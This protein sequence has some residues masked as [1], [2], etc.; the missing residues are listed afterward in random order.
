MKTDAAETIA[1]QA[2]SWLVGNDGLRD[3]FLGSTG[4][5]ASDLKTQ[6]AE[7]AFLASVLEFVTMDDTWVRAFC[8]AHAL[9]Y[10]APLRARHSLPGAEQVHWT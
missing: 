7:P 5:S 3:V 1:L 9:P 2:L 4:A 6:A 10:D 8:D